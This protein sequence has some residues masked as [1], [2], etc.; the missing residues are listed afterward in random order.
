MT[1]L[2]FDIR[3]AYT[4]ELNYDMLFSYQYKL[5]L[6]GFLNTPYVKIGLDVQETEIEE[7]NL[8]F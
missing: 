8:F 6:K 7:S 4:N 3:V 5:R 1:S 2:T